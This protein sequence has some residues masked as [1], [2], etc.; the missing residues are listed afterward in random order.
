MPLSLRPG[1]KRKGWTPLPWTKSIGTRAKTRR[2]RWWTLR[3]CCT[4]E[5]EKEE[6]EYHGRWNVY[7]ICGKTIGTVVLCSSVSASPSISIF[8]VPS[9]TTILLLVLSLLLFLLPFFKN[10]R[11]TIEEDDDGTKRIVPPKLS[12]NHGHEI[13]TK[14][15]MMM[16]KMMMMK[17]IV[18]V[19]KAMANL[20]GPSSTI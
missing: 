5:K 1:K 18:V 12:G 3:Y 6:N 9:S 14:M 15:R 17:L 8:N 16:M 19:A 2:G 4:Y 7:P 20:F 13:R 10:F 11:V